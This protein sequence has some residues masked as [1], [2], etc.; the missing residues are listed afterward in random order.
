MFC[1][2]YEFCIFEPALEITIFV[3]LY[4]WSANFLLAAQLRLGGLEATCEGI[5]CTEFNSHPNICM[6]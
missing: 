2:E 3:L 5:N 1:R 6:R 4:D